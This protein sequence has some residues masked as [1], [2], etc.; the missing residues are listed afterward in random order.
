M[1]SVMTDPCLVLLSGGI[2]STVLLHQLAAQRTGEK[3]VALA[4]DYGQRHVRELECARWQAERVGARFRSVD[5]T[6]FGVLVRPSTTL[7]KG[8]EPVPDLGNIAGPDRTQPPTYVPNRNMVLLAIAAAAAEAMG[9]TQVYYGA[10]AQDEYGYWDCTPEFVE[11]I[12]ALLA[13]NRRRPVT[14]AAPLVQHSKMDN[15][16]LGLR[17]GVD[18]SRTWSCYRGEMPACG[19]CPTC[20]ERLR[21]FALCGVLDPIPY[22]PA[23]NIAQTQENR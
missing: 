22:A 23:A 7:V 10:Q 13:L 2:D 16:R 17:L 19:T 20:M 21:A 18:F 1:E 8:A 3:V 5:L 4:F 15:V 12:N 11:R 6:F 14:V 9:I